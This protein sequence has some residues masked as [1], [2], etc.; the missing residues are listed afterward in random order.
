MCMEACAKHLDGFS[1]A[2]RNFINN[3][4]KHFSNALFQEDIIICNSGSIQLFGSFIPDQISGI[5][6]AGQGFNHFAFLCFRNWRGVH[7]QEEFP[8]M[9]RLGSNC[10]YGFH[11][12]TR[13]TTGKNKSNKTNKQRGH[14]NAHLRKEERSHKIKR[15]IWKRCLSFEQFDSAAIVKVCWTEFM[16]I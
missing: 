7:L 12:I 1:L 8:A 16:P 14:K 4:K 15:L 9:I 3:R 6:C 5:F 11:N 2:I 13:Q 10:K